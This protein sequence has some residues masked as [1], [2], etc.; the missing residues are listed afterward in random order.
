MAGSEALGQLAGR[1]AIVTGGGTGIGRAAALLLAAEGA[2]VA[3]VG[4][5]R[6]PL[7]EVV[8]AIPEG[9]GLAVPADVAD[10]AAVER[11]FAAVDRWAGPLDILVN[12]AGIGLTPEHGERVRDQLRQRL[13][14][15]E[16]G[17]EP[18]T[19]WDLTR[20]LSDHEWQQMLAINLT[21][22]FYT[23]RA[24]LCRMLP[25][26]SGSIIQIS[27]DSAMLGEV[28]SPHYTAA[29]AGLNGFAKAVAQE[30]A[31][32]GVRVNTVAPGWVETPMTAG[33][34]PTIIRQTTGEQIPMGRFGQPE[35][36]AACVLFLASDASS[37]VTGQVIV[38]NGGAWMP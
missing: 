30:V 33:L 5:R 23:T 9:A 3:V 31:S 22:C 28:I 12:S 25:R 6:E 34:N 10:G 17:A 18:V 24:A 1:V 29:K 32:R 26:G 19:P 4:R 35:E 37:F 15:S 16:G 38:P 7:E 36:V 14:E 11:L 2:R 27:S 21:G 8:A 20:F 13:H